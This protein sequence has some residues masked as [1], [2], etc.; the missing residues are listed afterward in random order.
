M[1]DAIVIGGGF[2]GIYAVHSLKARGLS[3]QG[4]ETG[5]DVGGTWYWNRYPG[6]RCDVES[7]DYQ[8]G[9]DA[10]VNEGWEWSERYATQPEILRYARWAADKLDVRGSFKF[11]TTVVSAEFVEDHWR[12][13]TDAGEVFTAGYVIAASG[14]I[15][16]ASVPPF[17]GAEKFQGLSL[18][19]G[20]W[21]AGGVDLSG[22]RVA[23]IGVGSSGVQLIPE[24]AAQCAQLT[25][26][27][28]TPAYTLP[29]RNRPLYEDELIRARATAAQL[30]EARKE[31]QAGMSSG[32]TTQKLMETAEPERT[33]RLDD[34]WKLGGNLFLTTFIDATYDEQA[35]EELAGYV[36]QRIAQTV[37][38]PQLAEKLTPRDYPI[39]AKRI[40][41]DT[42]FLS[43]FNREHV[44]LVDVRQDPIEQITEHGI[45]TRDGEREYD[46]IIYATGY[47]NLTGALT[48]V[49]YRGVDGRSLR[50]HW[51]DGARTY[52]GLMAAGFPNLFMITGPQS[53]SVLVNMIAAI[54]QH[55]DWAVQAIADLGAGA[56]IEPRGE[57]ED[58][59][60]AEVETALSY[61]LYAKAKSWYRGQ[62]IEG[63]P[64]RTLVYAGGLANYRQR[65]AEEAAQG[66]PGFIV[67][68]PQHA[69][70]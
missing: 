70:E 68:V 12:L 42:N 6:A 63:K 55:V 34:A 31:S 43:T 14:S 33:R 61:T 47:D 62:N 67:R 5:D 65:C 58:E 23:V 59:W 18:H 44:D 22:K 2:A 35:N 56:S 52:L 15:S 49:D 30:V 3:A 38:D 48:R 16:A 69:A 26:Y 9:F 64:T 28:R 20:R 41:T 54:E 29:A 51:A 45:R 27:Q 21:P 60:A 1:I 13:A 57:L 39:G 11:N 8:Y 36:R 53:P 10:Q 19:P 32:Y 4:F 66:Y 40:V 25:V 37:A 46:V 17:E 24:V 50:E 7:L